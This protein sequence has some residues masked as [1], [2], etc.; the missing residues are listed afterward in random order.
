VAV[1]NTLTGAFIAKTDTVYTYTTPPWSSWASSVNAGFTGTDY[2]S[3]TSQ[4]GNGQE[5]RNNQQS[6]WLGSM[7]DPLT[8]TDTS[9]LTPRPTATL[10]NSGAGTAFANFTYSDYSTNGSDHSTT[11]H[12]GDLYTPSTSNEV[13]SES[14]NATSFTAGYSNTIYP[15][16]QGQG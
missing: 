11:E 15:K 3:I 16:N 14:N 5:I 2:L 10:G 13:F 7:W 12:F 8:V 9:W 6:V 1:Y 4:G